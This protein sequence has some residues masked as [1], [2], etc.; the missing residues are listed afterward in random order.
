MDKRKKVALYE[1]YTKRAWGKIDPETI[2]DDIDGEIYSHY[3]NTWREILRDLYDEPDINAT[4][5]GCMFFQHETFDGVIMCACTAIDA[6][7]IL[8]GIWLALALRTEDL[9]LVVFAVVALIMATLVTNHLICNY[10]NE[11]SRIKFAAECKVKAAI[12]DKRRK[13][14]GKI[15]ES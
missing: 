4:M 5:G 11:K 10:I 12:L 1:E 6:L 3:N 7:I 15:N 14:R 9:A 13:E 8:L 2:P